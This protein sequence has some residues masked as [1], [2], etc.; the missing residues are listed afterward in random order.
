MLSYLSA[1]SHEGYTTYDNHVLGHWTLISVTF[2]EAGTK[3]KSTAAFSE[4]VGR[5]GERRSGFL[6]S[7]VLEES[8]L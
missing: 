4:R 7:L 5:R 3:C 6:V 8:D 1:S 2:L